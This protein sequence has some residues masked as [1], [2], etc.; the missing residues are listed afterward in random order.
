LSHFRS[1][2]SGNISVTETGEFMF[3]F[4]EIKEGSEGAFPIQVGLELI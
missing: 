2:K 1:N 4:I 3:P